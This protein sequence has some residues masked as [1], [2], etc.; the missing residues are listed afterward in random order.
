[1]SNK[2]ENDINYRKY[3]NTIDPKEITINQLMLSKNKVKQLHSLMS[4]LCLEVNNLLKD[5]PRF[6]IINPDDN[7]LQLVDDDENESFRSDIVHSHTDSS[8]KA[9]T[10][11]TSGYRAIPQHFVAS[12]SLHEDMAY[13]DVQNIMNDDK[14]SINVDLKSGYVHVYDEFF[15]RG[16]HIKNAQSS[17]YSSIL[18]N[19]FISLTNRRTLFH[20]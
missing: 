20:R 13:I 9:E 5:Y 19:I 2:K 15:D 14:I 8:D 7:S 18:T 4:D 11:E 3:C 1:M 6:H 10:F 16:I 17:L 12:T